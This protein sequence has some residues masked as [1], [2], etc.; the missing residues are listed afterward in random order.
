MCVG[1]AVRV[2]IWCRR[3]ATPNYITI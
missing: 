1:A 2:C 3:V